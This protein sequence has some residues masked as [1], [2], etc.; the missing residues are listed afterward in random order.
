MKRKRRLIRE[1][2][3]I[4]YSLGIILGMLLVLKVMN[5]STHGHGEGENGNIPYQTYFKEH[6]RIFSLELPNSMELAGEPV[7]M[8]ELDVREKLD[9]EL[10]VNTYWQSHSLLLHKRA[11]RWFPVIEPILEE[12]GV[13]ED[14]KFIP[15]VESGLQNV[16]SPVGARGFWQF[17]EGTAKD[18]GLEVND[19]VDER[20]HVEKATRAACEYLK[21]A[22]EKYGSWT[23]ALAAYNMGSNALNKRIL[24]QQVNNY[25]QLLLNSETSRYV[26]RLLALKEIHNDPER[27]GF[28]IREQDLYEPYETRELLVDSSIGDLADFAIGQGINYKALKV[29]NPWLRDEELP[30]PEGKEYRIKLPKGPSE[31]LI[32]EDTGEFRNDTLEKRIRQ[33]SISIEEEG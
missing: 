18:Y 26:F 13:P 32:L 2:K 29:L 5:Y 27:Y 4:L 33:D 22:K 11:H 20:Y 21:D 6:Y 14:M 30:N 31:E 19:E 17:M 15:L 1:G 16:V 10:H 9:R 25:Y 28:H 8:K 7:P 12:E 23:L 24:Q 3:R